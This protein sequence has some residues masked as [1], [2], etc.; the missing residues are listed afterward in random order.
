MEHS[1]C[2]LSPAPWIPFVV[3][4]VYASASRQ[5]KTESK[6]NDIGVAKCRCGDICKFAKIRPGQKRKFAKKTSRT[7]T[8]CWTR[9]TV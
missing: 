4:A 9:T 8:G 5:K 2:L 6:M 1:R 7:W 3:Y